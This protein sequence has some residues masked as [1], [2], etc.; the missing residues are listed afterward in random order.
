MKEPFAIYV[1]IG[2]HPAEYRTLC[3]RRPKGGSVP[4]L[5]RAPR[6]GELFYVA[7]RWGGAPLLLRCTEIKPA[8]GPLY[9][10]EMM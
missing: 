1:K 9:Y 8:L 3:K 7:C 10:A 6:V 5:R 2:T 4:A